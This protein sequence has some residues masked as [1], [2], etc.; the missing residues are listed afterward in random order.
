MTRQSL[1][2]RIG[3]IIVGDEILS[4]RRQDQHF[5]TIV[6]MLADRGMEL[7]WASIVGDDAEQLR[8]TYCRSFA[9][10]DVVLSCGGIG[11][12]P[13]DK[14]RQAVA[15]ALN[16]PLILHPQARDLIAERCAA[17]AA[18]GQGTADMTTPENLQRLQ[19]GE[20][21]EGSEIVANPYN[22][23]P[24]FWIRNHTF[25][26]G[27]PVM[28]WPMI[29][30][31]LDTRYRDL[32]GASTRVEHSF[33]VFGLPESRITPALQEVELRWPGVRSFSLPSV[34]SGERGH[35]ELGVKGDSGDAL[36]AIGYLRDEAVRLGGELGA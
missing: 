12:T 11:A 15:A 9:S 22:Q 17:M 19:M 28:A 30:T 10:G 21:P 13:D 31:M 20:F 34:G 7:S 32:H 1:Q 23:I 25:V 33:I 29:E 4:G 36:A 5:P 2:P 35:I 26:P 27:F 24:G 18:K 16:V 3:L 6:R 8:D 14:T